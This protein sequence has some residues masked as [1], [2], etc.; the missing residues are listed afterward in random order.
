MSHSRRPRRRSGFTL[1]ELLLVLA[2]L[3]ILATIVTTKF[4]GVSRKSKI[5]AARTQISNFNTALEA[6]EVENSRF[7][8]DADGGLQALVTKPGDLDKWTQKMPSIPNDPWNRPY[9]YKQPGSHN[10]E[11]YDVYSLGEDGVEG[12][13][14]I[15]N[16]PQGK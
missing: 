8:T 13:D 5:D 9:V 2:I 4:V 6:F 14:D 11:S 12:N 7:P 16:W 10:A 1:I 3:A 15:G